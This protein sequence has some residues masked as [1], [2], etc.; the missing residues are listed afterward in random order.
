VGSGTRCGDPPV[1]IAVVMSN[2]ATKSTK[3]PA[4]IR[5]LRLMA[6]T[7]TPACALRTSA[8]AAERRRR[9]GFPP[10]PSE[11]AA[12]GAALHLL[13]LDTHNFARR[14]WH[15]ALEAAGVAP[16]RVYDL[17]H[18]SRPTRSRLA[19]LSTSFRASWEQACAFLRCT[20]RTSFPT[21]KMPL[22]RS[23]M[24]ARRLCDLLGRGLG[25]DRKCP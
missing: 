22:A 17:R 15:P 7:P 1:P 12:E 13:S 14:D 21:P 4:D 19:S 23:W 2:V 8:R 16:R 3:Q 25:E 5:N 20:T 11:A 24:R 10:L 18:S 6:L 9:G